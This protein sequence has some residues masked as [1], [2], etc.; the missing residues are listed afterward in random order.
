LTGSSFVGSDVREA[1]FDGADLTDCNLVAIDLADASFNKSIL[2]RTNFSMSGL[3]RTKFID[4]KLTDVNLS[5]TDLMV[6]VNKKLLTIMSLSA[7]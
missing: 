3:K 7:A 6:F 2:V 4:V 5:I 1:N